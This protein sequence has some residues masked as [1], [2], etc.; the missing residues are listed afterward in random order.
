M[1]LRI[2]ILG[3]G[4]MGKHHFET[5][6]KMKGAVVKAICDID[7]RKRTGD[8]SSIAGNIGGAGKK[9]DLSGVAIYAH[10]HD[11]V[12]DPDLDVI[13]ITSPTYM[14]S[15]FAIM[16]LKAGKH[17]ICEKPMART[18]REAAAMV[19]AARK[20]R[21]K[22][23][24]AHC[25]RYWPS[26][27]IARNIVRGGKYG[28][29]V[30]ACF[31]RFST[32]PTWSWTNWL[33]DDAKSGGA[34]LDLH[35]HDADFVLYCF[36]KPKS[37]TARAAGLVPG[38]PDHVV[39]S[40][41]YGKGRLVVAEGG[42]EYAPRYAFNMSF[43]IAMKRATLVMAPD[44]SLT[45]LP[46]SGGVKPV[47]VPPGDGYSHELADFVAC[48]RG[49]RASKVVTPESALASVRLIEAEVASARAGKTVRVRL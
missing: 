37:V 11:L 46:V 41:D 8:W 15:R 7:H 43:T 21:R 12:C 34:A 26:Y 23:F 31:R 24:V 1:A 44:L 28:P 47:K 9:T 33:L 5:Y 29:V 40:Y 42:W 4:F 2:G 49:N 32:L 30:S 3:I 39:A 27:A 18:S 13:D 36:G 22:L 14:H 19:A 17:V 35:V 38:R 25:I 16:A 10:A 48:I 45:L 20:A 6:A